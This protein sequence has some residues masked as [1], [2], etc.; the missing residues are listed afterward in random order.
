MMS[1]EMLLG[2]GDILLTG[3]PFDATGSFQVAF[4]V[5]TVC[6]IASVI[7]MAMLGRKSPA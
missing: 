7:L 2:G 4:N 6:S 3:F 1:D 5:M